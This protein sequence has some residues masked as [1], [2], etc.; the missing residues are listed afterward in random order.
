[1]LKAQLLSAI[2]T[3]FISGV[4][5]A[6]DKP[7]APTLPD[8]AAASEA[9]MIDAQ[10]AVKQYLKLGDVYLKCLE[11]VDRA[12]LA[13]AQKS[14]DANAVA[15]AQQASKA[16]LVDYNGTVDAMQATGDQFNTQI[17]RFKAAQH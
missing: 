10:Q 5:L 6:C 1:M 7:E 13:E 17:K 14:G 16:R 4:S 8:G 2:T 9:Q 3:L 12:A 11:N 15:A